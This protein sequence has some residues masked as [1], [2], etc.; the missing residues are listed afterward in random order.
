MLIT[1]KLILASFATAIMAVEAIAA[2]LNS[3]SYTADVTFKD[4]LGGT[5]MT[6]A[7]DGANYW[8]ASGGSS[9]GNRYAEYGAAG[10]T[11]TTF[12]PGIDFRSVFTD[13]GSNVYARGYNS[14]TIYKQTAPG[15]FSSALSL[16]GGALDAQSAVVLNSS[17]NF[18]AM[19]AGNVSIW[20]ASGAFVST[21][22]L[23]GFTNNGYPQNRGIAAAGNY[24][25]TYFGQTLSAWDYSGNLVDQATLAGAGTSFDSYF[26]LS[27]ANNRIFVV[28]AAG[29]TWRG[30]DIGVGGQA[31][32]EP[33]ML[34]LLGLG[35][36][37]I[38]FSQRRAKA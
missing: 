3:A 28:D 24:L 31:V 25:F 9:G 38:A 26:S 33:G 14:N 36:A 12:A 4:A 13:G 22:A 11:I 1:K 34:I 16:V 23:S 21:F 30:Y 19:N 32:P 15:V 17:G 7:F 10:N 2:P 20:N 37:G 18:V 6:I 27:Y 29:G 35:F 5:T 8:S